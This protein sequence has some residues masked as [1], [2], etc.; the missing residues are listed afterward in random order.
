MF[1]ATGRRGLWRA[2]AKRGG[3][4][5]FAQE[6]GLPDT[7]N[8]HGLTDAEIRTRLRAAL[9]GSNLTVWPAKNWLKARAGAEVVSAIKR[10]GGPERWASELGL[11][12]GHARGQRWSDETVALTLERLLAGRRT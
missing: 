5:H 3:P 4:E 1:R 12:R 10:S 8:G 6:Y 7:R 9:R 11:P 2:I